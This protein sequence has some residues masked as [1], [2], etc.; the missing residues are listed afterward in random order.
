MAK[1]SRI[2]WTHH[3]FNPWWGCVKVSPGCK[4]CYAERM[5]ERLQAM[6]NPRYTN[7]FDLT[8]HEDLVDLPLAWR[9]PKVIFVN[10]MSD[11]FQPG[12]PEEFVRR[13]FE[14]MARALILGDK[15][16]VARRT[17]EG[18]EPA[19]DPKEL[20][21]RGLIPGMDVVGAIRAAD[22]SSEP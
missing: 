11:L 10:S 2:E 4:H 14:T 18:L 19:L 22:A 1:D 13:V 16:T 3:T 15:D 7:G 8:L 5:A 12:I 9:K 17:K 20:I 6:G 21:F